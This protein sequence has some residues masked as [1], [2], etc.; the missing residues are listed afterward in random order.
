AGKALRA[1]GA[2][3]DLEKLLQDSDPRVR[4]AALDGMIDYNYWFGIGDNP[5]PTDKFTPAMLESITKML[6]DPKESWWVV[7]GAL[8]ALK[9]A[10]ANEIQTRLP[11]IM[12]WTK[13]SDWWFR[14]SAFAALSGLQKDDALYV[15]IL[16]TLLTLATSE[17]H[18]MPRE[19]MMQHLNAALQQKKPESDA[20]KLILAALRKGVDTGKIISGDR[21]PEGV[22][23]IIQTLKVC[24]QNDPTLAPALAT[25]LQPRF[26]QLKTGDLVGILASPGA[27]P[28]GQPFGF[29]SVRE[30]L[31]STQR[32]ELED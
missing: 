1:T 20:G 2:F 30:K 9:F 23:N 24:L 28:A 7:N 14:D 29:F 25:A 32:K 27:N 12:P 15:E 13:H 19:W 31:D 16:P 3:D 17:Y 21:A 18:T 10:P 4:R 11:L 22:H 5:I 6:T 26:S 8:M